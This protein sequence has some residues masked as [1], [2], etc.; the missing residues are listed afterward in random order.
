MPQADLSAYLAQAQPRQLAELQT[1]LSIPSISTLAEHKADVAGAGRWLADHLTQIG[2]Q[3]VA[4]IEGDGHPMVYADWLHAGPDRPTLLIYGHFDVQPVDPLDLWQTPPFTPTVRIGP[5]GEDLYARGASDDKGQTFIHV[6]AVEALLQTADKLPVNVKFLIEG[7]E[8][9]GSQAITAYVPAHRAQLAADV[10]VVSDT[11]ILAPDQPSMVYGLRGM[12]AGEIIVRGARRD[13]H[14]GSF[15]GAVHNPNQA[16]AE[17][18]AALH[19][20]DGRIAV[21]GFY[22]QV[23]PLSD[24]ERALLAHSPE[25]EDWLRQITGAPAA[26]GEPGYTVVERTGARPTL[27]INGM[28]GGF[29]GQGFKTV[30]P[31][32][33]RAK[34]SCRLVPNQDPQVIGNLIRAYVQELAPA[35]VTVELMERGKGAPAAMVDIHAPQM[36]AATRAYER[37]FGVAPILTREGGSIPIVSLFQQVL[38]LP[39]LL[40]GFGLPD[41]NL[42]APNEKLHLPNFYRGIA[43]SIA[44]M[45]E[46]A[47]SAPTSPHS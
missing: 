19:D 4:L 37:A 30:I 40:M 12:W 31:A 36:Q 1:W 17:L 20:P 22:D 29:T 16:L 46:L 25:N 47:E 24:E 7:E 43:A 15:G 13:L 34:I 42:H 38:D 26:Y 27:E 8:E 3:H 44:L 39:V 9:S 41:D 18:L 23:T 35:T 33:A 28:W 10:C 14:S 5:H 6:K 21:P 11:G 32:E 2:L 45:Q